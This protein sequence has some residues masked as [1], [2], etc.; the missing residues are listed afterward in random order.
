MNPYDH[1]SKT[2]ITNASNNISRNID[3]LGSYIVA[4]QERLTNLE[5]SQKEFND[6]IQEMRINIMQGFDPTA[7]KGA[8]ELCIKEALRPTELIS[9]HIEKVISNLITEQVKL[10]VEKNVDEILQGIEVNVDA[11]LRW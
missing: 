6:A 1:Y 3:Y 7:M 9:D 5:K 11:Q 10:L 8:I 2:S 4:L